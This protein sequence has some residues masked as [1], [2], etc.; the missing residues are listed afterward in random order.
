MGGGA[1]TETRWGPSKPQARP[2]RVSTAPQGA[3]LSSE[4]C[5]PCLFSWH[6]QRAVSTATSSPASL[7]PVS[8]LSHRQNGCLYPSRAMFLQHSGGGRCSQGPVSRSPPLL[9]T[10]PPL[11]LEAGSPGRSRGRTAAAQTAQCCP[12]AAAARPLLRAGRA[13]SCRPGL[14]LSC[15]QT[16][17]AP[18]TQ[19][20]HWLAGQLPQS[21]QMP[22]QHSQAALSR[23]PGQ[24][25]L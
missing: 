2:W 24:T 13:C 7:V 9:N 18:G 10:S 3:R 23:Y 14:V 12:R 8:T 1:G 22:T 20:A 4:R 19:G 15:L 21:L 11:G 25:G 5:P 6:G 16:E 17:R